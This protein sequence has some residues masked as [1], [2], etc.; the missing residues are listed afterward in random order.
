MF[1]F[2]AL[3]VKAASQADAIA[4]AQKANLPIVILNID[5]S[6]GTIDAMNSDPEHDTECF[7]TVTITSPEGYVSPYNISEDYSGIEAY[8]NGALSMR[9]RG[10][11]SWKWAKKPY[12][13][14][15]EDGKEDLF[16]MGKNKKWTL[17][18]NYADRTLMR[19]KMIYDLAD[20]I[21][22]PF[23][24]KSV[25]VEVVMNDEY[26]GN[27]ILCEKVEVGDN[28]VDIGDDGF[29]IEKSGG[30]THF[31]STLGYAFE[32]GNPED[33]DLT[34]EKLNYISSY[35]NDFEEAVFADGFLNSE[36]KYYDDLVDLDSLVNYYI[37]TE[38][39]KE[40]D[41]MHKSVYFYKTADEGSKMFIGP[42]WDFDRSTGNSA[43][44]DCDIPSGFYAAER[45][46]WTGICRDK[47]FMDAVVAR[48]EEVYPII[49]KLYATD[50]IIDT[51]YN[52]LKNSANFERWDIN[53]SANSSLIA[54]KGSYDAE[55]AHM[56][57]FV[58]TRA[59]WLYENLPV[60]Q[61]SAVKRDEVPEPDTVLAGS[62]T[63]NDPYLIQSNADF[64][65]FTNKMLSG[66]TYAGKYLRQTVSLDLN[67]YAGY[68]GIGGSG[69]FFGY[70]DGNGHTINVNLSG[71][72]QSVFPYVSGTIINLG[73]T[74][75]ISNTSHTGALCRSVR[76]DG[77]IINCYTNV[78]ATTTSGTL[79]GIAASCEV[80][81]SYIIN[82][83]VAG[84]LNG[85]QKSTGAFLGNIRDGITFINCYYKNG[86]PVTA[87]VDG[88]T[89]LSDTQL[90]STM[91]TNLNNQ[92]PAIYD[93]CG[94]NAIDL[95]QYSNTEN[96][97]PMLQTR[98][99]GAK[100]ALKILNYAS[101]HIA[102]ESDQIPFYDYNSSN[103]VSSIDALL[104]LHY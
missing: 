63:Q 50:G 96:S 7:G 21:G 61:S 43:V 34:V 25:F 5:E 35:Y 84:T 56:K 39:S 54:S 99:T 33:E 27:Y 82:C 24:A 42:V 11:S 22:L 70:Y 6:K 69:K 89:A 2:N 77:K 37:L 90:K 30:A 83:Y 64:K 17:I 3:Q 49:Q 16:G 68:N 41:V 80:G 91:K 67:E 55:V 95:C 87:T 18:A 94:I 40:V 38:L 86:L 75:T 20:A 98:E 14:K 79:G 15:L 81:E 60:L 26:L 51:H 62:G 4:Q 32:V 104:A 74:G 59:E 58:Q 88:V 28:R 93:I 23:S 57:A 31:R 97:Y 8:T 65:T 78:V 92:L 36:G 46:L 73:I 45:Y 85:N 52:T 47:K 19:N 13:I 53:T 12:Q 72:D 9:G 44:N 1:L 101:G 102:L 76:V 66:T 71:S 48:Y 103:T 29:L 100:M 10:S